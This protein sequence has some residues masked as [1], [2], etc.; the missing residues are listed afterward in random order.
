M[1]YAID[2]SSRWT[3]WFQVDIRKLYLHSADGGMSV[4]VSNTTATTTSG[5]NNSNI[6]IS[7]IPLLDG[8]TSPIIDS[9]TTITYLDRS[10]GQHVEEVWSKINWC[11]ISII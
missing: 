5:G 6:T 9:G 2:T 1:V 4:V 10:L 3:D 11:R 8:V 7:E